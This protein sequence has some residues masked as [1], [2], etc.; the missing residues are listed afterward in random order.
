MHEVKAVRTTQMVPSQ[1]K[2]GGTQ[3]ATG[4]SVCLWP[5][6]LGSKQGYD[7]RKKN[8]RKKMGTD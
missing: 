2:E 4:D 3:R 6:A 7:V 8:E 5:P 1:D